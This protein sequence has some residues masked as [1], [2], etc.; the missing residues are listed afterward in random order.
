MITKKV[1]EKVNIQE[2]KR[3][4]TS[5]LLFKTEDSNLFLILLIESIEKKI[6]DK[7]NK[8]FII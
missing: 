3:S 4:S 6:Y 7:R 1:S 2:A 5:S 8:R